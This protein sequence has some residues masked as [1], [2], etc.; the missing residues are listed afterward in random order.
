MTPEI[1]SY[2]AAALPSGTLEL[3]S[4]DASDRVNSPTGNGARL[5]CVLHQKGGG[6]WDGVAHEMGFSPRYFARIVEDGAP[7]VAFDVDLGDPLVMAGA[8]VTVNFEPAQRSISHHVGTWTAPPPPAVRSGDVLRVITLTE[9]ADG[10]IERVVSDARGKVIEQGTIG[11]DVPISA[12]D[13]RTDGCR[14]CGREG[15]ACE[16]VDAPAVSP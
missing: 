11:R 2:L 4:G 14:E 1:R 5:V 9:Y 3:Y 13:P 10:T 15:S 7:L 16:C 8:E 12:Y 6:R